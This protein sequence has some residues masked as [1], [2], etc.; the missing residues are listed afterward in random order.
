M[1]LDLEDL[2]ALD[3]RL[4]K[5]LRGLGAEGRRAL[6]RY[7][8]E[9]D[10]RRAHLVRRFNSAGQVR[11]VDLLLELEASSFARRLLT[12]ELESIDK[13]IADGH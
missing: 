2:D 5:V 8:Q 12:F 10:D 13:R 4:V 1:P 6:L 3:R 7:L 9:P 11:L